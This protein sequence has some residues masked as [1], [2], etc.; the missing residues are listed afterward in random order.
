LLG[1]PDAPNAVKWRVAP[2][3]VM[4][5]SDAAP[6]LAMVLCELATNVARHAADG[7]SPVSCEAASWL[8][9][10]KLVITFRDDGEGYPPAVLQ[11]DGG[12]GLDLV[13]NLVKGSLRGT[14]RLLNDQGAVIRIELDERLAQEAI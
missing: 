5:A 8:D 1:S 9:G 4:L 7:R 6:Q 14:I 11:G 13:R 12:V 2:S 3:E 10:P